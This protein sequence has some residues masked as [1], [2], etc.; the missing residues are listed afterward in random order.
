MRISTNKLGK[1]SIQRELLP[2]KQIGP[3][4]FLVL[5]WWVFVFTGRKTRQREETVVESGG[6]AQKLS[7]GDGGL[8]RE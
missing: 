2:L 1:K 5:G 3:E 7:S 8:V 6:A 4:K